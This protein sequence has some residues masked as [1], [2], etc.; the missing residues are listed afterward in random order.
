MPHTQYINATFTSLLRIAYW[1]QWYRERSVHWLLVT[2]WQLINTV[3][4]HSE[5]SRPSVR[6]VLRSQPNVSHGVVRCTCKWVSLL[7]L[8]LHSLMNCR[9]RPTQPRV[10]TL[11]IVTRH[12]P[13]VCD[14]SHSL[15]KACGQV[16]AFITDPMCP[17]PGTHTH[18]SP[19]AA[20]S[21][22]TVAQLLTRAAV[23]CVYEIIAVS[24]SAAIA[25]WLDINYRWWLSLRDVH[26]PWLAPRCRTYPDRT[27][28]NA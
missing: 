8:L 10:T 19:A 25:T 22:S 11:I 26:S 2:C 27:D 1:M 3:H 28:R 23:K 18:T 12:R 17:Q 9:E 14:R 21:T 20:E 16:N 4:T 5:M 6:C 15:T 7:A 13:W 24:H